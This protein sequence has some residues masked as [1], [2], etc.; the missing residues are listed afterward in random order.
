MNKLFVIFINLIALQGALPM[1]NA[2]CIPWVSQ[3]ANVGYQ[4]K[5]FTSKYS[6]T[7]NAVKGK[8]P[9]GANNFRKLYII[10]LAI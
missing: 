9:M 2:A 3:N 1:G 10:H 7:L 4:W 5:N 6:Q 8:K